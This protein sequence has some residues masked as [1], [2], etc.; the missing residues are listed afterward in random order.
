MKT[1]KVFVLF[2]ISKVPFCLDRSCLAFQDPLFTLGIRIGF[3][4]QR[5][6]PFVGLHDFIAVRILFLIVS[7]KTFGVMSTA[8]TVRT[9]VY[10]HRLGIAVHLFAS[11]TDVAQL[12]SIMADVIMLI[13]KDSV[14]HVEI[15]PDVLFVCPCLSFLMF[16]KLDIT[17]DLI[18]FQIQQV[19]Q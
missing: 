12:P 2:D 4:L 10:F 18:L 6:P 13:L 14:S 15:L 7:V 8:A 17:P 16:L 11:R 1:A 19:L 5:F 3:L 9:A